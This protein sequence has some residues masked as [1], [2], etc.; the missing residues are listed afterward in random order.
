MHVTLRQLEAFT[1]VARHLSFTRAAEDM[2]LTQPAVSMQIKQLEAQL[3]QPLF[4]QMGKKL[5]LTEAGREV[6]QYASQVL[7]QVDNLEAGL[8]SLK[9]LERGTLSISVATTAHYFAP[10]LLSI[11]YER[12]PGVNVKL[13]VTNR[14]SLVSQLDNNTVDMVIMGRPPETIDVESG[15][16]ME[17]PL[18]LIAPAGHPFTKE[19]SIQLKRLEGEVFLVRE[20]GSGTRKAMEKFF[21]QHN[22][23]MT[24]GME[25]SSDE[26]IKQSVQAGLGLGIMSRD[27]LQNEISLGHLAVPDVLHFPIMRQWYVMHRKG[28]RLSPIATAFKKFLLEEAASILKKEPIAAVS[29]PNPAPEGASE[30]ETGADLGTQ[31]PP[32]TPRS[33]EPAKPKTVLTGPDGEPIPPAPRKS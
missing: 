29:A 16:F 11:F 17:N 3:E 32:S 2:N 8:A 26:A 30:A 23:K 33:Y 7:Q 27:A 15:A 6:R 31:T 28:K 10:K 25:V 21:A 9:G 24:T 4:E 5:Y 22:I 19:K 18:V 12:Y 13:D 1:A 20:E 14:E